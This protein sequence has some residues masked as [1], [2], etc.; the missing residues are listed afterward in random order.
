MGMA[1]DPQP[2][3]A[4]RVWVEAATWCQ[5]CGGRRF[6]S[7]AGRTTSGPRLRMLFCSGLGEP[8]MTLASSGEG[9]CTFSSECL[10]LPVPPEGRATGSLPASEAM[11]L[12]TLDAGVGEAGLTTPLTVPLTAPFSVGICDW[13]PSG[14]PSADR[15]SRDAGGSALGLGFFCLLLK[16]KDMVCTETDGADRG[17]R[18]EGKL[19]RGLAPRTAARG[20]GGR[21][22][23]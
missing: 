17:R 19:I 4:L 21:Q 6:R 14:V 11:L 8:L 22:R 3:E 10:T 7:M 12:F 13:E 18:V 16:R 20:Q 23:G 2:R 1:M 15:M 5:Y 9:N